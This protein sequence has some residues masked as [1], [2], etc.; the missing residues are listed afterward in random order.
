MR[1]NLIILLLLLH[2]DALFASLCTSDPG[3]KAKY[4]SV[5]GALAHIVRKEVLLPGTVDGHPA[6]S[7][8]DYCAQVRKN[9]A[10]SL[11]YW[12]AIRR[13]LRCYEQS[14]Q[15]QCQICHA[16]ID[17]MQ[18]YYDYIDTIYPSTLSD[19]G[20][21]LTYHWQLAGFEGAEITSLKLGDRQKQSIAGNALPLDMTFEINSEGVTIRY[22]I[23]ARELCL[24]H[25]DLTITVR[26][27]TGEIKTLA[28]TYTF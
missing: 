13:E 3:I 16:C 15:S 1:S 28:T 27:R 10:T 4:S 12:D 20:H 8:S 25:I 14:L 6:R 19:R 26:T 18:K 2:A 17:R 11:K 21:I 22:P 9:Y 5:P 24:E 23:S 7:H